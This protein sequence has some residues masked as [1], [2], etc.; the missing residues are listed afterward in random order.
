MEIILDHIGSVKVY[1]SNQTP[2]EQQ[3]QMV[4]SYIPPYEAHHEERH[5]LYLIETKGNDEL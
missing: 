4:A 1:K 2:R 3:N 5:F